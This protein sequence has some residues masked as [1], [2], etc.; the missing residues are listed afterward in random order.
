[1]TEQIKP[2]G[3][4]FGRG[5]MP[6]A[7]RILGV[8]AVLMIT[9]LTI[10][11]VLQFWSL[12]G[13][14]LNA[15]NAKGP[16]AQEI[17]NLNKVVFIIAGLVFVAV[18]GTVLFVMWKYREKPGDDEQD[19]VKQTEGW[20]VG[21]VLWTI[22][23]GL[24]LAVLGVMTV[25]SIQNLQ[26]DPMKRDVLMVKVTGNQWWWAFDYDLGEGNTASAMLNGHNGT[27][28]EKQDVDTATELVVPAGTEVQLKITSNDVIHS[29]WIP[30]LNGKKDAVPNLMSDWKLQADQPG[31]YLGQCTEFC[32]LSH[33]N[34]RM[35]VRAL[36]MDEWLVW[37]ENQR[38]ESL[39]PDPSN[40]DAVAGH[41]YFKSAACAQC[42]LIRG[43]SDDIVTDSE[44]GVK[45]W[46]VSGRAPDL[47]HVAS[48]GMFAGAVFNLH[49]PDPDPV[50]VRRN[51]GKPAAEQERCDDP[52]DNANPGNPAN[53]IN[54]NA[55]E[56]WLR[57]PPAEKPMCP[58]AVAIGNCDPEAANE[59]VPEGADRRG[60]GMPNLGLT[61]EQID[62][63]VAYL[64][65]L[66]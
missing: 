33:A 32:G 59:E 7:L 47:T 2:V 58:N 25:I 44:N 13:K 21:E 46:L 63:L 36:P 31:V 54:R 29:F 14:P 60:R 45:T 16:Q 64:S 61:E 50:C 52:A 28:G 62:Q 8:A 56:A 6:L 19:F 17:Q 5:R 49:F 1:M 4:D 41:D 22:A 9:I 42:H 23:P 38:K 24:V 12:D 66:K 11:Q 57:N 30:A 27:Y 55:L 20:F 3:T 35:L 15:I 43:V 26:P 18:M 37:V 39:V 48:R 51:A 34:M 40:I 65:T 10:G 53:P